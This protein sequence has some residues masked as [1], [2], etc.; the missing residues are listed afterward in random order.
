MLVNSIPRARELLMHGDKLRNP[1]EEDSEDNEDDAKKVIKQNLL[2]QEE[3]RDLNLKKI[4]LEKKR[5]Q[6]KSVF[7][8]KE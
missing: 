4:L 6:G 8:N 3:K 7:L 1:F 5:K 2:F